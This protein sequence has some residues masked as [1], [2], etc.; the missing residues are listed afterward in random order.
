MQTYAR[1]RLCDSPCHESPALTWP[2]FPRPHSPLPLSA[3][4]VQPSN[5]SLTIK[6]ILGKK[7]K[8]NRPVPQ[9]IR[10]RTDNKIRYV[11]RP[12]GC[13][14]ARLCL[15]HVMHASVKCGSMPSAD[16]LERA[17]GKRSPPW[18][19]LHCLGLSRM[20]RTDPDPGPFPLFRPTL[21]LEQQAPSLAPHQAGP[22]NALAMARCGCAL[23]PARTGRTGHFE[24]GAQ[25][26]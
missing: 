22:I 5:K 10:L 14:Y 16:Y 13:P 24:H 18:F 21:Q 1:C 15:P 25:S 6:K 8:Q 23:Q 19:L 9:W 7:Q 20:T 3:S 17:V 2:S 11:P 12:P 4:T 26:G